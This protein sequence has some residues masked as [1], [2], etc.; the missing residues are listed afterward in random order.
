[1][2]S[3]RARLEEWF[4]FVLLEAHVLAGEPP[5]LFQEAANQPAGTAPA[6]AALKRFTAGHERRPWLRRLNKPER[7]S[8]LLM[9]IP[10]GMDLIGPAAFTP[11]GSRIVAGSITAPH[12]LTVW[13]AATG[14]EVVRL[15]VDGEVRAGAVSPKGDRAAITIRGPWGEWYAACVVD[16]ANGSVVARFQVDAKSWRP[17]SCAYS[18]DGA[19][20]AIGSESRFERLSVFDVA[21][22]RLVRELALGDRDMFGYVPACGFSRDGRLVAAASPESVKVWDASTFAEAFSG[23]SVMDDDYVPAHPRA[24]AFSADGRRLLVAYSNMTVRIWETDSWKEAGT[25]T[26]NRKIVE[27]V[28]SDDGRL[29]ACAEG[30]NILLWNLDAA[31]DPVRIGPGSPRAFGR[32]GRLLSASGKAL[33]VWGTRS[34]VNAQAGHAG[35]ITV[36]EFSPDGSFLVTGSADRTLRTWDATHG[37]ELAVLVGHSREVTSIEFSAD[38]RRLLSRAEDGEIAWEVPAGRL[39]AKLGPWFG[40]ILTRG[41]ALSPD[42]TRVALGGR[43]HSLE[44]ADPTTGKTLLRFG[45]HSDNTRDFIQECRFLAGGRRMLSVGFEGTFKLWDT[46]TGALVASIASPAKSR[47]DWAATADGERF[48]TKWAHD[49]LKVWDGQSGQEEATIKLP[50]ALRQLAFSPDS[51]TLATATYDR[52][53]R[54]WDPRTGLARALFAEESND[55]RFLFSPDSTR[56]L[57]MPQLGQAGLS[58]WDVATGSKVGSFG[59]ESRGI[60]FSADGTIIV[61]SRDEWLRFWDAGTLSQIACHRFDTG[62]PRVAWRPAGAVVAVGDASGEL[63]LLRLEG[64]PAAAAIVRIPKASKAV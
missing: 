41:S 60:G 55:R 26:G 56:L 7:H 17:Y 39:L 31:G 24:L 6:D 3:V 54:F 22:G 42:G 33:Q 12:R 64:Y 37:G 4:R 61:S 1:M 8:G 16:L 48:L 18:P 27:T 11:E 25:L 34:G 9:T 2:S 49:T 10:A 28:F 36:C 59:R 62:Y 5:L 46:E 45:K 53:I 15:P 47:L 63:H 50:G 20:V 32:D 19:R 40:D 58:V 51:R 29:M 35:C 38:S 13:D 23:G 57:T 44:L 43:H 52:T 30:G 14:R 21:T